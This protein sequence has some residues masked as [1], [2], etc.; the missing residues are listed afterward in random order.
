MAGKGEPKTGGRK[1]GTPNRAT[2]TAADIFRKA[3]F[4]PL[5][6]MIGLA[7]A[8]EK[9]MR[10]ID[11][12]EKEN[13]GTKMVV[14]EVYQDSLKSLFP[15]YKEL[16]NYAHPKRKAVELSGPDEGPIEVVHS[17]GAA[18]E[19]MEAEGE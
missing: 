5:R 19:L 3:R 8:H 2:D 6:K 18:P 15:I 16:M 4:D 9:I 1:K 7:R 10:T 12:E 13:P 17:W 11:E 14:L